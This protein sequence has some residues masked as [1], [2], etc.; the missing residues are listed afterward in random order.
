MECKS[1]K[2]GIVKIR[3]VCKQQ[4]KELLRQT[5]LIYNLDFNLQNTEMRVANMKGCIDE[6]ELKKL[7]ERCNYLEKMQQDKQKSEVLLQSQIAVIEE[8]MK[9]MANLSNNDLKEFEKL[10]C[11]TN[12]PKYSLLT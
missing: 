12:A 11:E 5:V 6:D 3:I 4:E 2:V 8:N 10:V 7:E 9:R 1:L